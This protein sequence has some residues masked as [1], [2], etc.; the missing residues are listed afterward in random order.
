MTMLYGYRKNPQNGYIEFKTFDRDV[1]FTPEAR[2]QGWVDSPDKVKDARTPPDTSRTISPQ[3]AP[4]PAPIG[5][6]PAQARMRHARQF[7]KAK[8]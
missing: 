6:T 5:E 1:L 7:R 3:R 4:A 2:A 8:R